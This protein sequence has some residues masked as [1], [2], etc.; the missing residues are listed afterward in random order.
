MRLGRTCRSVVCSLVLLF[1]VIQVIAEVSEM[2]GSLKYSGFANQ[3]QMR[4][5]DKLY[6]DIYAEDQYGEYGQTMER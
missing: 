5:A 1:G 4:G 3:S 6:D 2:V